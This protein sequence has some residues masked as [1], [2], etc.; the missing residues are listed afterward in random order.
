M[1]EKVV[2][3]NL[4]EREER[5]NTA[6]NRFERQGID[7]EF[8]N[9]VKWGFADQLANGIPN[10]FIKMYPSAL[11]TT[12]DH[13]NIIKKAYLEKIDT[14]FIF[15]DD[16][17]FLKDHFEW[18]LND[19]IKN[20]PSNWDMMFLYTRSEDKLLPPS[21]NDYWNK[22]KGAC[23][24]SY[25]IKRKMFGHILNAL[26]RKMD[27]I[28]NVTADM[29]KSPLHNIF[30]TNPNLC[31]QDYKLGSNINKNQTLDYIMRSTSN[32]YGMKYEDY[33]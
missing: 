26:D 16:V 30:S 9:S 7:V 12:I 21:V 24:S 23:V 3:I 25:G 1:F 6:I 15:E 17:M 27:V 20:I 4:L 29:M 19:A 5:T 32:L 28:D 14:L 10:N 22:A 31:F 13:Y 18:R 2:C 33:E 11:A 8:T